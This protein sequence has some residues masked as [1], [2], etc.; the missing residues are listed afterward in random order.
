MALLVTTGALCQTNP[1][2]ISTDSIATSQ[3]TVIPEIKI[4]EQLV[5]ANND[6]QKIE[7]G[8]KPESIIIKIDSLLPP[9]VEFIRQRKILKQNFIDAK[10]NRQK[11]ANLINKWFGYRAYLNA[12]KTTVNGG[13]ARKVI[14]LDQISKSELTWELTYENAVEKK[15][16]S[17]ILERIKSIWNSY[18]SIKTLVIDEKSNYLNLENKITD[19]I[20]IIDAVIEELETLKKSEVYQLFYPRHEPFW[21]KSSQVDVEDQIKKVGVESISKNISDSKN[22]INSQGNTIYFFFITLF[23]S[24]IG[25]F[26]IKKSFLKYPVI[27]KDEN[28][29]KVKEIIADN[30]KWVLL[31]LAFVLVRLFFPNTPKLFFDILALFLIVS[32]FILVR[33]FMNKKFRNVI[34]FVTLIMILDFAKTYIWLSSFQYRL[35][36]LIETSLLFAFFIFLTHH[37]RTLRKV[38][39]IKF[40]VIFNRLILVIYFLIAITYASNILGY[41]NLTDFLI[42]LFIQGGDLTLIFYAILLLL[43][44]I[45]LGFTDYHFNN[46]LSSFDPEHKRLLEYKLEKLIKAIAILLWLF[47][48][49]NLIDIYA[50][51]SNIVVDIFSAPYIVGDVTFTLGTIFMFVA[52]LISSYIITR[53][54][55]FL[56]DGNEIKLFSFKLT[57]GVPAAISLVIRY[58][59]LAFG[60]VLAL[61]YIGIDLSEFNLLAGALGLGI[62]F[63]LQTIVSNFI[64][65]IILIFERPILPGD[66]VEVN[67][68]IGTVSKIGVRAS[69]INTYE[70]AEVVVP[71][72]NLISEDLINWTLSNNIKRVEILIGTKYGTDPNEVLKILVQVAN[73][74]KDVLKNPPPVALFDT[75]GDSSLNYR[76]LFWVYFQ[77]GLQAKSDVSIAVYNRFIELGI[78]IPFPQLDVYLS[79]NDNS[80]LGSP[81][82]I[83]NS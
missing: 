19:Q 25:I 39:S 35:Y 77:K 36:L 60:V 15:V 20:I 1:V 11:I 78:E 18:K 47:Y 16:P 51:L 6:I 30:T 43:Y 7:E 27:D 79:Q 3:S 40:P 9:Y 70:G 73:E 32:A 61:S 74:N 5:K 69:R 68:L 76:L 72:N 28:L 66:V 75:F 12:W 63:G 24:V 57:K 13:V 67:N 34:F 64:S 49:L 48:L 10:P 81:R 42:K 44:G 82:D 33:P 41:T 54:I 46:R 17:Q 55:S 4:I 2:I 71:N 38:D 80:E 58:F 14:L 8:N 59:I 53:V 52:I 26:L 45:I 83:D 65:G 29:F 23:F 22:Y 50:P 62:G 56:L 21:A 31:F 37:Y